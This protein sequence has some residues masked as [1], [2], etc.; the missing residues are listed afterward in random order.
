MDNNEILPTP[1]QNTPPIGLENNDSGSET[2]S[3]LSVE[4]KTASASGVGAVSAV[5]ID[6][7]QTQLQGVAMGSGNTTVQSTSTQIDSPEV[8]EDVDLIEKE[9][10]KRA[11]DI[12]NATQGDPREQNNQLSKIKVDYI[13]KRY[14]KDIKFKEVE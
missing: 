5:A 6:D 4:R 2:D 8:A 12:V 7:A 10:V 9:W 11:K 3:S 13:K 14:N 1:E